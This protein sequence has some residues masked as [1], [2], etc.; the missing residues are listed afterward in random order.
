MNNGATM[1]KREDQGQR[2]ERR[3]AW[4]ATHLPI[5]RDALAGSVIAHGCVE[6]KDSEGSW[7]LAAEEGSEDMWWLGI[8]SPV[9]ITGDTARKIVALLR[10]DPGGR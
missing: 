6:G 2:Q 4:N 8:D 5:M 1:K 7:T 3:D 10:Q 9:R